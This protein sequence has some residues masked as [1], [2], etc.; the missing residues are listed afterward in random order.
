MK[1]GTTMR[2]GTSEAVYFFLVLSV[3]IWAALLPP[4]SAVALPLPDTYTTPRLVGAGLLADTASIG[5]KTE[6]ISLGPYRFQ[7]PLYASTAVARM[8]VD[9]MATVVLNRSWPAYLTADPQQAA[10]LWYGTTD[11][12]RLEKIHMIGWLATQWAGAT[13]AQLGAINEA[14]WEIA[15]DHSGAGGSL[16]SSGGAFSLPGTS[17]FKAA[18][19]GYVTAAYTHAVQGTEY[20]S[21]L[22]LIPLDA[23]GKP[24]HNI[25]PLV[26]HAPEPTTLLL[27]GGGL[28][29]LRE[30]H[31]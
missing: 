26:T 4:G 15:A 21:A 8:R 27:L 29:G 2:H 19:T 24:D 17:L 20:G 12:H 3:A 16:S 25:Q 10:D 9:A 18:A 31:G 1:R 5:G 30:S 14:A 23:A 11:P 13:P 22:F 6:A 7:L 28:V